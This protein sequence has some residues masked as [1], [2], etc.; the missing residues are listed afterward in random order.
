MKARALWHLTNDSSLIRE[1]ILPDETGG[2]FLVVKSLFSMIS[3][4]T[5]R[6]V[7][8]GNI[9]SSLADNMKVPYQQG[10]LTLPV[11]YGYS[12][13]GE[14]I[15]PGHE[16][17]GRNVHLLHPHQD[18]CRVKASDLFVIPANIPA[19]RAVLASNLET[20]VNAIWDSGISIGDR[21]LVAGL[22][23]LGALLLVTLSQIPG[24]EISVLEKNA[25]RR[26]WAESQG[27]VSLDNESSKP[28]DFA[29]NTTGNPAALQNC[30]EAVGFEGKIM[31]LS[32]YGDKDVSLNLGGS[33]HHQRKQI[34]SSQVS[35]LPSGRK[36]RWDFKRRKKLVFDLL[37][38]PVYDQLMTKIYPF[39]QIPAL[40][41]KIRKEPAGLP[42]IN[43]ISY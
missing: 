14:V 30:I 3:L 33:F 10:E 20:V 42:M 31:E 6:L 36:G 18:F 40:F 21:V 8:M 22:G 37:Q 12:L 24:I 16:L 25:E 32:W 17:T 27:F 11:S 39:E 26:Q 9:P 19:Q 7:A 13:A 43:I 29:C 28:F 4:G 1:E 38:N 15:T 2:N 34:I 5:E 41:D 23:S 35:N